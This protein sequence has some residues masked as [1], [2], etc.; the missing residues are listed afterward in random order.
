LDFRANP[1]K[2]P[3]MGRNLRC[4]PAVPKDDGMVLR[5]QSMFVEAA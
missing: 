1:A 3:L 5:L 2:H 4:S